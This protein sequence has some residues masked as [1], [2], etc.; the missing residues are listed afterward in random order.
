MLVSAP[1]AACFRVAEAGASARYACWAAVPS[2]FARGRV[3]RWG[4]PTSLCRAISMLA[5]SPKEGRPV[6]STAVQ[7]AIRSL[8]GGGASMGMPKAT[9]PAAA[10]GSG[11]AMGGRGG[12]GRW[13]LSWVHTRLPQLPIARVSLAVTHA[14][15]PSECPLLLST[16]PQAC[17]EG[18]RS[19]AGTHLAA[20]GAECARRGCPAMRAGRATSPAAALQKKSCS[21][22]E[23]RRQLC[24]HTLEQQKAGLAQRPGG[25]LGAMARLGYH[26]RGAVRASQADAGNYS[27]ALDRG[28]RHGRAEHMGEQARGEAHGQQLAGCFCCSCS[29]AL[30]ARHSHVRGF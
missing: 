5:A 15:L 28:G 25:A 1:I 22:G 6:G 18:S 23:A 7:R 30:S 10:Q 20:L 13:V 14:E 17:E 9:S 11:H 27:Y 26:L 12:A 21:A 3:A 24:Y 19:H 8:S 4:T 2:L 29:P 16:S